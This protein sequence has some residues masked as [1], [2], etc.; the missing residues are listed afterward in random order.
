M[1]RINSKQRRAILE[2]SVT[3]FAATGLAGAT[4][5][6]VGRQA[7]VNSALIYYYFENKHQLF[8]ETIRMVAGD[9]LGILSR[10]KQPFASARDRIEFLVQGVFDY[11]TT[12][13][14]RMR[15]MVA[16]FSLYFDLL[17]KILHGFLK[18]RHV[19]PLNIIQE[20]IQRGELK[21]LAPMQLWWSILGMCIFT[22]QAQQIATRLQKGGLPWQVPAMTER[23]RQII[24][25]LISG[26]TA[27]N[28]AGQKPSGRKL[29][30]TNTKGA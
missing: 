21:P 20:G 4:I 17:A 9:F 13:P 19:A 11:Y 27:G 5:R 18:E 7:G 24:E 16:V 25:I 2:A 15:L 28:T 30:K 8:E 26:V 29:V 22:M 10:H 1:S 6:M 3:V 23:K 14:E 12:H